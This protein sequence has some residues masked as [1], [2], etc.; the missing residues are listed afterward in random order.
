MAQTSKILVVEDAP[1]QLALYQRS[2]TN[3]PG[4]EI[5]VAETQEEGI[6]QVTDQRFDCIICDLK[7]KQGNGMSV[8]QA[9]RASQVNRPSLIYIVSGHIEPLT[10][11]I[12][13][14][15]QVADVVEKPISY[16]DFAFQLVKRL[17]SKKTKISYDSQLINVMIRS[18]L[19]TFE[20]YFQRSP[21]I[22]RVRI[23]SPETP[24]RGFVTAVIG[25]ESETGCGT[26]ALSSNVGFIR[27]LSEA[28]L[29]EQ[30]DKVTQ[31]VA[32]DIMGEVAN[33]TI[34]RIKIELGKQGAMLQIG[35]P[36]VIIEKK[37][38]HYH[39]T[40][41][42]IIFTPFGFDKIGCDFEFAIAHGHITLQESQAKPEQEHQESGSVIL[43]D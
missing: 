24:A 5:S 12:A 1:D 10:R 39:K 25:F 9:A 37:P 29:G 38:T 3:F 21:H 7:L 2:L 30:H 40:T 20:H 33:Q 35:L 19:G 31:E 8:V 11:K 28:M 34:G 14:T 42:P 6:R 26:V 41:N 17:N 16:K 15:F 4:L 23:K 27:A 13:A 22:G 36:E 43:F 18:G 32:K